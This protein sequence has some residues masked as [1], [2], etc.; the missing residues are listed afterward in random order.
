MPPNQQ[1]QAAV[2]INTKILKYL[3]L[4]IVLCGTFGVLIYLAN[5]VVDETIMTAEPPMV[6]TLTTE[7]MLIEPVM[8]LGT[9][10]KVV[11]PTSTT[12]DTTTSTTVKSTTTSTG[13]FENLFT[14]LSL[15]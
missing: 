15:R 1:G 14:K 6:Y 13:K 3:V 10:E 4:T 7:K 5:V 2:T 12:G 9:T 11:V 8:T